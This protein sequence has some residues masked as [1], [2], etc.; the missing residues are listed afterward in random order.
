MDGVMSMAMIANYDRFCQRYYCWQQQANQPSS[1][2][3][4]LPP[5]ARASQFPKTLGKKRQLSDK[6]QQEMK[7]RRM[8]RN[9]ESAARSRARKL[10]YI[11][12]TILFFCFPSCSFSF[13]MKKNVKICLKLT[14]RTKIWKYLAFISMPIGKLDILVHNVTESDE[15]T[16]F[17]YVSLQ[18]NL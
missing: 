15:C 7:A 16:G 5:T 17:R 14:S 12:L 13:W 3:T 9:R 18:L 4:P 10:V 8:M 2:V 11:Y 1:V 6:D